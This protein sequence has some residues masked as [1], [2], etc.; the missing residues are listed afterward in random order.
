MI[1]IA[2]LKTFLIWIILNE[3]G[4]QYIII[5]HKIIAG[6]KEFIK[7]IYFKLTLFRIEK[8]SDHTV[9]IYACA[10]ECS[11]GKGEKY[12]RA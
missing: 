3:G 12:S 2:K 11:T 4:W 10:G 7:S 6:S 9:I 5:L 1:F 8:V